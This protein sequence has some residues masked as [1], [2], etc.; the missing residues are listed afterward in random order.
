MNGI[1]GSTKASTTPAINRIPQHHVHE[2]AAHVPDRSR[3]FANGLER[4]PDKRNP[5]TGSD[6][7]MGGDRR[8]NQTRIGVQSRRDQTRSERRKLPDRIKRPVEV[9]GRY[10]QTLQIEHSEQNATQSLLRSRQSR[11]GPSDTLISQPQ[12]AW[13]KASAPFQMFH[14]QLHRARYPSVL[15]FQRLVI[16]G[17]HVGNPICDR[18]KRSCPVGNRVD[19]RRRSEPLDVTLHSLQPRPSILRLGTCGTGQLFAQESQIPLSKRLQQRID[20]RKLRI[21]ARLLLARAVPPVVHHDPASQMRLQP[22]RKPCKPIQQRSAASLRC[23]GKRPVM[24]VC[25][26]H[27]SHLPVTRLDS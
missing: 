13:P 21:R 14:Q 15:L 23:A 24:G 2:T 6:T 22:T 7:G 4:L 10:E 9:I 19:E 11:Q 8:R 12:M 3:S 1:N 5:R 20:I 27:P 17:N 18:M 16:R 26:Q 25:R